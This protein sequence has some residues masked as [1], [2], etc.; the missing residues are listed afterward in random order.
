MK[1]PWH[2]NEETQ[3]GQ[4]LEDSPARRKYVSTERPAKATVDTLAD[5]FCIG[6]ERAKENLWA[7]TQRGTRSEIFTIGC[8][9]ISDRMLDIKR[10]SGKSIWSKTGS[11]TNN[12]A[13]QIYTYKCGFN[14][15]Y[16]LKRANGEQFG[17]S[18]SAFISEFG[19]T[20]CLTYDGAA[21]QA[22]T[23]TSFMDT[24]RR[25]EI[26]YRVSA[27]RRP[28]ENPAEGSIREVKWRFYRVMLKKWVPK[29]L[30]DFGLD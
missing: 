14:W 25:S 24:V 2:I 18:L 30:W 20:D 19:A 22:C 12:V 21:V 11:I 28:N 27:L 26:N 9:Y 13:S 23:N 15:L 29:R 17:H 7:T 4:D 10:L 5:Q 6:P 3:Y 16:H 1:I 8:H